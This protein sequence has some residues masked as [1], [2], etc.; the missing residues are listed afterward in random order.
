MNFRINFYGKYVYTSMFT[1]IAGQH[2]LSF[3]YI[4]IFCLIFLLKYIRMYILLK[5]Q[6][7][8]EIKKIQQVFINISKFLVRIFRKVLGMQF[9]RPFNFF[10]WANLKCLKMRADV[11]FFLF[12]RSTFFHITYARN[13]LFLENARKQQRKIIIKNYLDFWMASNF[14]FI[15]PKFNGL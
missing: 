6:T 14:H 3:D 13:F 11:W 4:L 2:L 12:C 10:Y 8:Y 5:F 7:L 15:A 1:I 9:F